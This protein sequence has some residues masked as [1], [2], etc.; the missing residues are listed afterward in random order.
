MVNAYLRTAPD[1]NES[2]RSIAQNLIA[3]GLRDVGGFSLVLGQ[4]RKPSWIH[5]GVAKG[6]DEGSKEKRWQGLAIVSNRSEHVDDVEWICAEPGETHA[7]SNAHYSDRSWP[8]VTDGER[9]LAKAI[10][11]S[12]SEMDTADD[13]IMRLLG[14]LATDTL[15]RRETG[16]EFNV[17]LGQLRQSIFIPAIGED[18]Q[19][20]VLD[21]QSPLPNG[22]AT[23]SAVIDSA[24]C[25]VYGTQKQTMVLVD[26]NGK[27]TYVERTLFDL[28]G[29]AVKKGKEDR[30]FEFAIEGW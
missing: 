26:W 19:K 21:G 8:K 28:D 2:S 18:R 6:S 15:P 3:E 4:L 7:L 13:L 11:T 30:K 29:K 5:N 24:L 1:S 23:T 22:Q 27:V 16:E 10:E 12:V 20:D 25:G 14:V 17:Y 9:L